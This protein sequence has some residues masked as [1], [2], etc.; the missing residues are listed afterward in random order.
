MGPPGPY[1]TPPACL[2]AGPSLLA[3]DPLWS[4]ARPLKHGVLIPHLFL[5]SR[6]TGKK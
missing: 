6:V 4:G 3:W 5:L 2:L 1:P